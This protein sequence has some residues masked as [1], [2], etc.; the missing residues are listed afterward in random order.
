ML[1]G[2]KASHKKAGLRARAAGFLADRRGVAAIE[3]AFMVPVLL[4]MYLLSMEAYQAIETSKKVARVGSMV[5][6]LVTQQQSVSTADL[7]AIM[8][9][10][11]STMQPYNRSMPK[12]VITA[13]QMDS[14]EEAPQAQI[15]WSYQMENGIYGPSPG[16]SNSIPSALKTPNAFL[17][18]VQ[19][20]LDYKPIMTWSG[21]S[22]QKPGFLDVFGSLAMGQTYYLRPR[23]SLTIPCTDC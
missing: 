4:V 7:A 18:R 2:G 14:D 5:A 17:I 20:T 3:F 16:A 10:G 8:K 9:I 19:S 13:I 11:E 23:M 6:D 15:V 21:D 12:V 1:S 22:E